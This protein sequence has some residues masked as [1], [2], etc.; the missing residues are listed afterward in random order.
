MGGSGGQRT[1]PF[2]EVLT[3][4]PNTCTIILHGVSEWEN[5]PVP[6]PHSTVGKLDPEE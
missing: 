2:S 1:P 6:T 3:L 5:L 4:C